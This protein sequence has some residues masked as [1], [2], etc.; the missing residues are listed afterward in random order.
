M[1]SLIQEALN[2]PINAATSWLVVKVCHL[3]LRA[4]LITLKKW[5]KTPIMFTKWKSKRLSQSKAGEK[6]SK[7]FK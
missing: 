6:Q 7:K 4:K 1:V 5:Q 2:R 3:S